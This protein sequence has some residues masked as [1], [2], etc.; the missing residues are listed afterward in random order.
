MRTMQM[1]QKTQGEII[2]AGNG[3]LQVV[4]FGRFWLQLILLHFIAYP[5]EGHVWHLGSIPFLK[6]HRVNEDRRPA[7]ALDAAALPNR[8]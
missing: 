7:S 3:R 5:D 6:H 2:Y 8:N 4:R 1:A